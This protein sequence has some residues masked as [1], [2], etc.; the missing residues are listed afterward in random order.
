MAVSFLSVKKTN[1]TLYITE[2]DWKAPLSARCIGHVNIDVMVNLTEVSPPRVHKL[3]SQRDS[4]SVE[5]TVTCAYA[6]LQ[7]TTRKLSNYF[8]S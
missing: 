2:L 3:V 4:C 5:V 8:S 1:R 6:I 7:T